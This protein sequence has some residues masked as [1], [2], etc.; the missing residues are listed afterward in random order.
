L[1]EDDLPAFLLAGN[2]GHN[3]HRIILKSIDDAGNAL[4]PE[5]FPLAMLR[6][7]QERDI[8]VFASQHQQDP[9]PAGG[10]VFK[11]KWFQVVDCLDLPPM[12]STFI[13]ADTAETNKDYN[14]ASV[15]S[16][17]GL[18]EL[19]SGQMALHWIDCHEARVEPKDLRAE[20]DAF[21]ASCMQYTV[22]PLFAAIEKKSS[23]VTLI[24]VLED[25]RG[26]LIREV[27]RTAAS[28]SKTARYLEIQPLVAAKLIS[29][30]EGRRHTQ[31]CIAHM[32]KITA[33][34]THRHDDIADT[35]YDAVK[36]ALIDKTININVRQNDKVA[37]RIMSNHNAISKA[38]TLYG[39][40]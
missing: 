37:A 24:S 25:V 36:I 19:Q 8:Y 11:D 27:K 23:G 29:L 9:Q 10:A 6:T 5:A 18:Y 3:W 22:K 21:Y 38:R 17:W 32:L 2:D 15:F 34:N 35:L 28:G 13:T 40:S 20:F 1:H 31:M 30:P 4:Y 33:N 7:R 16:F 14:D 26:L 39:N 12:L